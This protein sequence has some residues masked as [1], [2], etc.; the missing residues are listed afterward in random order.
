MA[1]PRLSSLTRFATA[2]SASF[3]PQ[4]CSAVDGL[5]EDVSAGADAVSG[6]ATE[7]K[8]YCE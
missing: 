3:A 1:T 4:A 5:E 8:E 6:L 2:L 7:N